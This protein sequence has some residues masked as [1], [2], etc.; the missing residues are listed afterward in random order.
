M[1]KH[2]FR[3]F[4]A[5]ALVGSTSILSLAA[6]PAQAGSNPIRL[7]ARMSR[8]TPTWQDQYEME[9]RYQQMLH[10]QQM[11]DKRFAASQDE[12]LRQY[13]DR[14]YQRDRNSKLVNNFV[15]SFWGSDF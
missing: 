9:L 7:P 8:S 2:S 6:A 11:E 12:L 4:A 14:Q 3:A 10:Q 1:T 5:L 15:Q 13:N